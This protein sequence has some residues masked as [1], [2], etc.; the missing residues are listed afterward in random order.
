MNEIS[1]NGGSMSGLIA[2]QN[3]SYSMFK[4]AEVFDF[5]RQSKPDI[6]VAVQVKNSPKMPTGYCSRS[7]FLQLKIAQP[8]PAVQ[9]QGSTPAKKP[10]LPEGGLATAEQDHTERP[11]AAYSKPTA[12]SFFEPHTLFCAYIS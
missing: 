5:C 12:V 4:S 10:A 8:T 9:A 1:E 3:I 6:P 7:F 2:G 11:P